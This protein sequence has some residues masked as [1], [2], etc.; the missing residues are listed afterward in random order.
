[1]VL[2]FL[3]V[4]EVTYLIYKVRKKVK[5]NV[6]LGKEKWKGYSTNICILIIKSKV[7]SH[8]VSFNSHK[9]VFKYLC[10]NCE[11]NYNTWF[12]D[13]LDK[14]KKSLCLFLMLKHFSAYDYVQI[15]RTIWLVKNGNI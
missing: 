4:N 7:S 6:W 2:I 3:H 9:E 8:K 11:E 12:K 14:K 13:N 5:M 10:K 1:M 15:M